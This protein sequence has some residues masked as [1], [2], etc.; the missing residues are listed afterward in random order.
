G[1]Q[2]QA[3]IA[4]LECGV[5]EALTIFNRN[6]FAVSKTGEVLWQIDESSHGTQAD[7]PFMSL[8]RNENDQVVVGCWN[9]VTYAVDVENGEIRV[10]QFDR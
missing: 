9:G 5:H 1:A 6:I 2:H 4:G 8:Y 7:K 10:I 3:S